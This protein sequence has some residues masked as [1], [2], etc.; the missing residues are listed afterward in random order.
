MN[1]AANLFSLA[2]LLV[3]LRMDL[4]SRSC[5]N[6]KNVYIIFVCVCVH[7]LQIFPGRRF[8]PGK[9]RGGGNRF[10]PAGKITGL[11]ALFAAVRAKYVVSY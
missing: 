11:T 5:Y 7:G 10:F 6:T 3:A 1:C 4:Y 9:N 8:K 2:P